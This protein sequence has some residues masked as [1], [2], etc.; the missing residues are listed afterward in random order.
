[1]RQVKYLHIYGYSL[2]HPCNGE[3]LKTSERFRALHSHSI[4][5]SGQPL[6]RFFQYRHILFVHT[7]LG[8]QLSELL[9]AAQWD[10][11]S[12]HFVFTVVLEDITSLFRFACVLG[13]RKDRFGRL[14]QFIHAVTVRKGN[15]HI[16]TSEKWRIKFISVVAWFG[17]IKR[18]GH[19]SD[20]AWTHQ[21]QRT[22]TLGVVAGG[23]FVVQD[24]VLVDIVF[25]HQI[26][27]VNLESAYVWP[28]EMLQH[29]LAIVLRLML[30]ILSSQHRQVSRPGFR[31]LTL[32][33][34]IGQ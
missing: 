11:C 19:F 1:M 29:F 13:K 33:G 10:L 8:K 30:Q 18:T 26:K 14:W 28:P 32:Q 5:H 4:D 25:V 23:K 34:S 22:S 2:A 21:Q 24:Q 17:H 27:A 31:Y 16:V 3:W 6:V 15:L 7:D 20:H 9:Y 12:L